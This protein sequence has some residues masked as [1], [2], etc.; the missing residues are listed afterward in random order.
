LKICAFSYAVAV[1]IEDMQRIHLRFMFR[2]RSSQ[3]SKDKGEKN[4]AMA[5]IRLM[6]EDG[7]TLQ[8][9]IHDLLVLKGD[10]KKMEDANAYLTLPSTRQHIEN[11]GATIVRNSSIVGGLSVS[12]R[13]AFYIST[14]VCSTK[15]TQNVGLLGLLKWRMKPE[16]LQENLEK[17]KIVAALKYIPSVLHDV[18]MVFDAKLLSQLLY[19]FYTCIPPVKLQKQKVQSMKEIVRSNLFKKQECRDILLPVITKELKELLEQ[20][21]DQQL[22]VQEKKYCVELLNS[23]LEVLSCQDPASTYHHTQEI[24]VQLLRIVNRTVITMGREDPLIL[25]SAGVP[26]FCPSD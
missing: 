7:T 19:E 6:K 8:D 12:S 25:C 21:E 14:L 4:F 11:K 5:Y 10:S 3:E 9:G 2:H 16:L 13:D 22:Q 23:I 24:M 26:E 20:K 1:P 15:L 17:L 18:E